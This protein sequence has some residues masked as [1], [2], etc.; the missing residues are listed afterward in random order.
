MAASMSLART[1][2]FTTNSKMLMITPAT[3]PPRITR[4]QLIFPM[5]SSLDNNLFDCTSI[6]RTGERG[7]VDGL[8]L[9]QI[10]VAWGLREAVEHAGAV[11]EGF[12]HD[13]HPVQHRQVQIA[14]RRLF[15]RPQPSS[16]PQCAFA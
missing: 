8:A 10:A 14:E 16:R 4:V 6:D 5:V 15:P 2:P 7:R 13:A 9:D 3:R 12:L 1:T 11:S